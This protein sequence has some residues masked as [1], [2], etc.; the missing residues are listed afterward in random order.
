[1]RTPGQKNLIYVIQRMNGQWSSR[2]AFHYHDHL[3]YLFIFSSISNV[4]LLSVVILQ[5]SSN[6]QVSSDSRMFS[7]YSVCL[8][9]SSFKAFCLILNW[10]EY[11]NTGVGK[12]R[13]LNHLFIRHD[14][15]SYICFHLNIFLWVA[16]QGAKSSI[17]K[18]EILFSC[19][20]PEAYINTFN[21][22]N[23]KHSNVLYTN[24]YV[25]T[26]LFLFSV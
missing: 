7:V 21:Y 10:A 13:V 25:E 5:L 22:K 15:L 16:R 1:M 24:K 12:L 3:F 18:S 17:A 19:T 8:S 23:A 6:S 20:Q 2:A 26:R 9:A 4:L 11:S 14:L